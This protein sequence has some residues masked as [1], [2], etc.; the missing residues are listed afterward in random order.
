MGD[1]GALLLGFTLATVSVAGAPEDG[2]LG[3]AR[4]AAA[5]ARGAG[6]RHVV[7]RREAAEAPASRSTSPT[8]GICTT[9]S[10]ASASPSAGGRL[11]LDL[12]RARSRS[13][14]SRPA[15][16]RRT[17]TADWRWVERRGRRR[18]RPAR[19]RV[20]ALRRLPARDRQAREPAL[21]PAGRRLEGRLTS[22]TSD[23]GLR[24]GRR[25]PVSQALVCSRLVQ[26]PRP[27]FSL[28]GAGSVLI[29]FTAACDRRGHVDRL[30][31]G[32][33]RLRARLRRSR[34][35]PRR[36]RRHRDPLP[37]HLMPSLPGPSP[38]SAPPTLLP[39]DRGRDRDRSSRC[40]CSC[41][42]AGA[43]RGWAL[44]AVLWFG[45]EALG[46]GPRRGC[47]PDG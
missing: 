21:P 44:G 43:S 30:G 5:R 22:V 39:A 4:A 20:L 25:K 6:A 19:A 1:S 42:P 23:T 9:A 12:V 33:P 29:G 37:Q 7:R 17:S 2:R 26:P 3:D 8:R 10:C 41:S 14:R 35:Y 46:A 13:P 47:E 40:R 15:S 16:P 11:P 32:E 45:S 27:T 34:R 36:R 31:G 18:R 38:A 28:A 24:L